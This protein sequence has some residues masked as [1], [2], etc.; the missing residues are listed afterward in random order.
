VDELAPQLAVEPLIEAVQFALMFGC[1]HRVHD[2]AHQ[3]AEVLRGL[4][5]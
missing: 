1:A 5:C 2:G 4:G 3:T